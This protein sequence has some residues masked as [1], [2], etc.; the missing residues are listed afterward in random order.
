[1]NGAVE[2]DPSLLIRH[3]LDQLGYAD[4]DL[5]D[6]KLLQRLVSDLVTSTEASRQFKMRCDKAEL[7]A[8]MSRAQ[9]FT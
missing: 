2:I 7:Q 8:E 3:R 4:Y 1:M 9:V 6:V 5:E